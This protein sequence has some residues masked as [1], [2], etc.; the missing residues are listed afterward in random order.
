[1]GYTLHALIGDHTELQSLRLDSAKVIPLT[2]AKALIPLTDE[3]RE[4][5]SIPFLP[6]T[7]EGERTIPDA[8]TQLARR[9]RSLVYVEA[10]FF[11]GAGGQMCVVWENGTI[12]LGPDDSEHAIN[13]GLQRIGV[14]RST[15]R[16]EFDE[17]GLDRHRDT[18]D[19]AE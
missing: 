16:D 1:M 14:S 6:L 4:K 11:G 12:T 19:W 3:F 13:H 9:C 7:D 15:Q 18:E 5:Y 8:I 10:E 17:L 2:Q